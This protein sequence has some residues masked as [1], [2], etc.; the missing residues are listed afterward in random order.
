VY[1]LRVNSQRKRIDLTMH[2]P[3]AFGWDNLEIGAKLENVKVVSVES[4][5]AFVDFD[6]PKHG[7]VPFNLMPKGV[8]PKVGDPIETVWVVE[9]DEGKRRIG[10]TMIEPPELPWE[11]IRKGEKYNGRVTRVERNAAYVDIGAERE[12]M[13]RAS[14]MGMTYADMRA[15]VTEG[16]E[17]AVRVTKVDAN[18]RQIDLALEG[19]N[20]DDYSL[21]SGPEEELS[22]FA[23]ALQRAQRIK[24]AQVAAAEMA[25]K[26]VKK[27]N[28]QNDLLD[29]TLQH[30][31]ETKK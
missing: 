29:R 1:V 5:G 8:R 6:G 11:K 30:M 14:T 15:F 21:S 13:I 16:E 19:V 28:P 3:A 10:L 31:Q 26:P 24:R 12:G 18:R 25:D 17:I 27:N 20:P 22:P 4:F 7:L 9:V 23:A 2:K